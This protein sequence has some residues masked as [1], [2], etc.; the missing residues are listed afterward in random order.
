MAAMTTPSRARG[1]AALPFGLIGMLGVVAAGER[2]CGQHELDCASLIPAGWRDTAR[3]VHG[4]LPDHA[5]L[6]FGDSQVKKGVLPT[7]IARE[8]G[9]PAFN[10]ALIGGQPPS[11]YYVLR[12]VLNAGYHPAALVFDAYPG[13]F[14]S[15]PL[16]NERQWPELLSLGETIELGW[17]SF[18]GDLLGF[19]LHERLL[20]SLKLRLGVRHAFRQAVHGQP[21]RARDEML[22]QRRTLRQTLGALPLEPNPQFVDDAGPVHPAQRG[23]TWKPKAVNVRYLRRFL[24][25]AAARKIPVFWLLHPWS[26]NWQARRDALGLEAPYERL[27]NALQAEFTN[28]VVIDARRAGFDASLFSDQVHL[29]RRGAEI[30][31]KQVAQVVRDYSRTASHSRRWV[32]VQVQRERSL[33]VNTK[34]GATLGARRDAR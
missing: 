18:D 19:S 24:A 9:E 5:V 4:R 3:A 14:A 10:L 28:L 7:V 23:R 12:K 30:L 26:P 27:I 22:A 17:Q 32:L 6:C 11:S 1:S 29:D 25:L 33:A 21:N 31:S 8:L 20:P 13:L 16:I 2:F 15:D 34:A